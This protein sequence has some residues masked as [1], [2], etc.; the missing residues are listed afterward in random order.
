LERPITKKETVTGAYAGSEKLPAYKYACTAMQGWRLNMEDAHICA[1]QFD[2]GI[3]VF[4]VFDGHGGLECA[5]FCERF[6]EMKLKEQ[7]DYQNRKDIGR[8]LIN[9]FLGLDRMIMTPKGME[10]MIQ[11]SKQHPEQTTPIERALQ[12]HADKSALAQVNQN[13][14]SYE[15]MESKGCTAVVLLM[16]SNLFICA[17]AGDSRCV[18]AE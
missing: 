6:F 7:P 8:S 11:I 3:S 14:Y 2:E 17:N 4:A 16:V 18:I 9:T 5:K 15:S 1:P 13:K 12:F 10:A